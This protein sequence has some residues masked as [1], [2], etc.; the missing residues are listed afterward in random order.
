[1]N[2][3]LYRSYKD[4]MLGGVAGGLA[5]YFNIDSTLVR[6]LFLVILFVGGTGI[7]AYIIMWIIIP[8]EPIIFP[9]PNAPESKKE[10]T[11]TDS[12]KQESQFD[13]KAYYASLDHQREKRRTFA[14]II[15]LALGIILLADNFVPRIR[16]GDFWPLILVAVGVAILLSARSKNN[17][18]F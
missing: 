4:K 1:M 16:F 6:V 17:Y 3:K 12:S 10:E 18:N 13:T 5:E 9:N 2:K 8:E 7:L 15:I 11:G 14:G